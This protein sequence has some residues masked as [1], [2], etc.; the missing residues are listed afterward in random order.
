MRVRHGVAAILVRMAANPT[1]PAEPS[2]DSA[3]T[4]ASDE[5]VERWWEADGMPWGARKP[6]RK[7]ITCLVLIVAIA[8]YGVAMMPLQPIMLGF[9]PHLLA[10][11]GSRT[12]AIMVGALA[13]TGDLWW[14]VLL[15]VGSIMAMKFDLVFWWAGRLWG[16]GLIDMWSGR[17]PRAAKRNAR[18]ERL[19]SV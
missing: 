18:A 11:L 2:V 6:G 14:P 19:A 17:S 7:D 3:A 5:P 1:D 9:T 4:S 16:R 12:G 8:V 15:V 10:A 13:A